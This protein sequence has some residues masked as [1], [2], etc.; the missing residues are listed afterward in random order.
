MRGT[1]IINNQNL[2]EKQKM[3]RTILL[4]QQNNLNSTMRDAF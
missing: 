2:K 4:N 1:Q 3:E